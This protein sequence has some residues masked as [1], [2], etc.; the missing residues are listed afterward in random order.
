MGL[1]FSRP[2]RDVS[3]VSVGPAM[4]PVSACHISRIRWAKQVPSGLLGKVRIPRQFHTADPLTRGAVQ[5]ECQRPL[6]EG[7]LRVVHEGVGFDGEILATSLVVVFRGVPLTRAGGNGG[8]GTPGAASTVRPAPG[9]EPSCGL[10]GVP[11]LGQIWNETHSFAIVFSWYAAPV[12]SPLPVYG[13]RVPK[14]EREP[15]INHPKLSKSSI[16]PV[17]RPNRGRIPPPPPHGIM[18]FPPARR[19]GPRAAF[20]RR[21]GR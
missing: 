14:S 7:Q 4:R 19:G 8:T 21:L 18:D 15:L 12:C 2:P 13:S 5:V 17:W 6:A 3:A 1:F 11:K 16:F 20:F 9:H 10:P